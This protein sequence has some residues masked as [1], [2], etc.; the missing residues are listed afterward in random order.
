MTEERKCKFCD[1]TFIPNKYRP[2]QEICSNLECQYQR[3]LENMKKWRQR[4][5]NYFKYKETK[6]SSWKSTCKQ[7]SLDWRETHH[8]YLK[9]YREAH[10]ERHR[11]YMRE[12]M[13][14]YREKKQAKKASKPEDTKGP[15]RGKGN[16]S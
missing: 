13:R 10:R 12:Y 16:E 9:L 2:N 14:A 11:T 4:N 5:P 6:D 3:Q 15:D 1:K 8:D 7:R